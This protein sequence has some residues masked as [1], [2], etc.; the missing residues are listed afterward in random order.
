MCEQ[1]DKSVQRMRH[2]DYRDGANWGRTK[3]RH[4]H[5]MVLYRALSYGVCQSPIHPGCKC[6]VKFKN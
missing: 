1:Q 5:R 3:T 4:I 2:A 6:F